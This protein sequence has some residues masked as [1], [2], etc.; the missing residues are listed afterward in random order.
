MTGA[1]F[2]V[3]ERKPEELRDKALAKYDRAGTQ[4]E[5]AAILKRLADE[6]NRP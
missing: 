1:E 3:W 6:L 4:E 5:K 2:E